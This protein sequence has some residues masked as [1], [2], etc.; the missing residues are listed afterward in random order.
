MGNKS[1]AYNQKLL[2]SKIGLSISKCLKH[3]IFL[4]NSH[5]PEAIRDQET[6]GNVIL[7]FS[8]GSFLMFGSKSNNGGWLQVTDSL[9]IYNDQ[10]SKFR[11]IS[12]N[13][14]WRQF[15]SKTITQ[16]EQLEYNNL[17][18]NLTYGIR[19]HFDEL[20]FQIT[21]EPETAYDNDCVVIRPYPS[22]IG[23]L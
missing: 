22:I 21:Y 7:E 19:F 12:E 18:E 10:L 20:A 3:F 15:V 4:D 11:D 6:D 1:K 5:I 14:F 9:T 2:S 13:E 17:R 23:Y 16:I 8:D